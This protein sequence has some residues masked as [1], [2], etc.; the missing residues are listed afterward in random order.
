[1]TTMLIIVDPDNRMR[2]RRGATTRPSPGFLQYTWFL[3]KL[4]VERSLSYDNAQ[5]HLWRADPDRITIRM[6]EVLPEGP[7]RDKKLSKRRAKEAYKRTPPPSRIRQ[8][9]A[10]PGSG[11]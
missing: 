5:S 6:N 9:G 10:C 2:V 4:P 1:M 11:M 8:T 3:K 7:E